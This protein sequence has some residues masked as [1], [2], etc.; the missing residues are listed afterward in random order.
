MC[1]YFN[2]NSTNFLDHFKIDKILNSNQ[3]KMKKRA[4]FYRFGQRNVCSEINIFCKYLE[5]DLEF[6][7]SF[8]KECLIFNSPMNTNRKVLVYQVDLEKNMQ[9][10]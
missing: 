1:S 7:M 5:V 3:T 9:T 2:K 8:M 6:S 10:F 4:F